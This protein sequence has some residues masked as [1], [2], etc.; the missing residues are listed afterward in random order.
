MSA[1]IAAIKLENRVAE[2]EAE[3]ERLLK[4]RKQN[5][6]PTFSSPTGQLPYEEDRRTVG[7][8][9]AGYAPE[10]APLTTRHDQQY[11]EM[12]DKVI[13]TS[14]KRSVYRKA[15]GKGYTAYGTNHETRPRSRGRRWCHSRSRSDSRSSSSCR[16]H[17]SKWSI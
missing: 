10:K 2:L 15:D 4:A 14:M 1:D 7:M 9:A 16:R 11:E 12:D 5:G 17:R 8:V 6:Q 13:S 3:R